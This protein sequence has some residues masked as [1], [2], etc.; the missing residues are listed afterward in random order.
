[1]PKILNPEAPK[2]L[3]KLKPLNPYKARNPCLFQVDYM[4]ELGLQ[5]GDRCFAEYRLQAAAPR[6]APLNEGLGLR[7]VRFKGLGFKFRC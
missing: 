5:P 4:L 1:M 7:G 3:L 2:P 6:R